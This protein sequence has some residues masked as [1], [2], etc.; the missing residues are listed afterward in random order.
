MQQRK[1]PYGCTLVQLSFR[2]SFK[3]G[4]SVNITMMNKYTVLLKTFSNPSRYFPQLME[5]YSHVV[6][7]FIYCTT[8][9]FPKIKLKQ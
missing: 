6:T 2:H 4:L 8:G 5:M 7:E 9:A 1:V 3:L